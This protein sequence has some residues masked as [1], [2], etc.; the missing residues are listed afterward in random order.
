VSEFL[1][2]GPWTGAEHRFWSGGSVN[3]ID[4]PG[5]VRVRISRANNWDRKIA[6]GAHGETQTFNGRK[7]A[8]VDITIRVWTAEDWTRLESEILP[9]LEPQTGKETPKPL[10]LVHPVASSRDVKAILVDSV[11]GPDPN[12][13]GIYEVQIKAFEYAP[14]N[15]SNAT[16]TAKGAPAGSPCAKL[17]SLY[18]IACTDWGN[19]NSKTVRPDGSIDLEQQYLATQAQARMLDLSKLMTENKCADEKPPSADAAPPAT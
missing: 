9:L 4:L 15:K 6:K 3:G 12:D 13:N 16:G 7:A 8:D 19:A 1:S 10:D 18:S 5:L 11:A 17:A 2:G 14:V